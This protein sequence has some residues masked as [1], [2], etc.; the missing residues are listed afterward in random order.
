MDGPYFNKELSS[1]FQFLNHA[2][3]QT[4]N[5]RKDAVTLQQV[6]TVVVPSNFFFLKR[7]T[8][9]YSDDYAVRKEKYQNICRSIGLSVQVDTDALKKRSVTMALLLEWR[10]L[11]A[12][13]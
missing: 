5:L 12:N 9:I 8:L 6:Y 2:S 7:S 1:I 4:G 11:G 10:C 3:F 13:Y